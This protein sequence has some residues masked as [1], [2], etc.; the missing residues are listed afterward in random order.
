MFNSL[1]N[2]II[3]AFST[4]IILAVIMSTLVSLWSA[5]YQ[6]QEYVNDIS[7]K[8]AVGLAGIIEVEYNL[9][10]NLDHLD[11]RL[12]TIPRHVKSADS[13]ALNADW[14]RIKQE[15]NQTNAQT[16]GAIMLFETEGYNDTPNFWQIVDRW[17]HVYAFAYGITEA[18]EI[19]VAAMPA[20]LPDVDFS[21]R[22]S[23]GK[24]NAAEH[25][26]KSGEH[27]G[28]SREHQGYSLEHRISTPFYN[29]NSGQIVGYILT[30]GH[31]ELSE[32]STAFNRGTFLN[33][34]Y[35]G[36]ISAILALGIA[37]WLAHR[38]NTP[39]KAMTEAVNRL[40]ESGESEHIKVESQDELGQLSAAF[41]RM[42][43]AIKKQQEIRKQMITDLS[44]ELNTPLSIMNLEAKGMLDG[45]QDPVAAAKNIQRE[46]SL[47]KELITDLEV[48]AE[49]NQNTLQL[50]KELVNTDEFLEGIAERWSPK[51]K[52]QA[53]HLEISINPHVSSW[54]LDPDRMRQVLDNLI[55]NAFQHSEQGGSIILAAE[56]KDADLTLSISDTGQGIAPQDLPK[57]F[58]R[59]YSEVESS[60]RG[61]GLAIAKQLVAL[62]GG[63]IWATSKLGVGSVFYLSIPKTFE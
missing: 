55:R 2:R 41:N 28:D 6:L 57:I 3:L 9:Q 25:G 14:Q 15:N 12:V 58:D 4:T 18:K 8:K 32:E 27:D 49:A 31:D 24:L 46:I 19:S 5:K 47:L 50:K 13:I 44:H 61:L 38:I 42:S 63:K 40:T 23:S 51:A 52:L 20:F 33:N 59:F 45:M 62:H 1:R 35:G 16:V 54:E 36:L 43:E 60:E 21:I 56:I 39:V 53:I 34:I 11:T 30:E 17:Y 7:W 48:I 10:G 29:W 26:G 37:F 22:F